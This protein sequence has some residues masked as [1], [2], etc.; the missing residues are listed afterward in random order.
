MLRRVASSWR[1]WLGA[2]AVLIL[3]LC[4]WFTY[5]NLRVYDATQQHADALV[6]RTRLQLSSAVDAL[7]RDESEWQDLHAQ[8]DHPMKRL[9]GDQIYCICLRTREDRYQHM[10]QELDRIGLQP[11][12]IQF[13]RP[14]TVDERGGV[15]GCWESHCH[16]NKAGFDSGAPYWLVLEDDS[17]LD[18][19]WEPHLQV[20]APFLR[21]NK[22]WHVINLHHHG[23]SVHRPVAGVVGEDVYQ[24]YGLS[25]VGYVMSRRY[26]QY[27]GFRAMPPAAGQ[28]IDVAL[29]VDQRSALWTPRVYYLLRDVCTPSLGMISDNQKGI[30][31]D[32]AIRLLGQERAYDVFKTWNDWAATLHP[33]LPRH[34]ILYAASK[35]E[36]NRLGYSIITKSRRRNAVI[37]PPPLHGLHRGSP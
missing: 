32:I 6:E 4:C 30:L 15:W 8:A 19:M 14:D 17:H 11:K 16:V 31:V 28:H 29:F 26:F 20:L 12:D 35:E 33:H 21:D 18:D 2:L 13:Y 37:F 24:G 9:F 22:D 23:V 36:M 25:L 1:R 7:A 27:K 10:T 34:A 3:A 5:A